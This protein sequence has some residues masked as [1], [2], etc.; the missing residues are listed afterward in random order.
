M[1]VP[2]KS[3]TLHVIIHSKQ[4]KMM[5]QFFLALMALAMIALISCA[6]N[7]KSYDSPADVDSTLCQFSNMKVNKMFSCYDE[8]RDTLYF[9]NTFTALWPQIINGKPCTELQQALLR[10]MTDSAELNQLDEVIDFLLNPSNY[11][12]EL[13]A[14]LTPVDAVKDDE[15]KL[16]TSEIRINMENMTDRLLTY[17]LGTYS[18]MAGAAHGIYANNYVTYDLKN[19]KPVTFDDVIADTTLLRQVT[20]KS[21]KQTYDYGLDDLFIP[22]NGLLPLPRDFH[23]E[24]HVFHVVYQVYEIAS[25]AQGMIDAPIYPYMLKPEEIKRL[26]TPYGLELIDYTD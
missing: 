2:K 1:L 24:D 17:H 16:S 9:D 13:N 18:Y 5:R 6:N 7:D 23:F 4:M 22:D 19:D 15:N 3:L 10:A 25:Y 12:D 26:F 8:E 11:N 21:I 20:L 14:P